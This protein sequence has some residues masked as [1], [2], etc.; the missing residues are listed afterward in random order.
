MRRTL[1]LGAAIAALVTAAH[2]AAAQVEVSRPD[3]AS[4][5]PDSSLADSTPPAA[6]SV[7]Q[8]PEPEL[9]VPRPVLPVAAP[10]RSTP[11]RA[12]V[13]QDLAVDAPAILGLAVSASGTSRD[14]LGLLIS[15]VTPGGPADRGGIDPGTRLAE[16][17]SVNLRIAAADIGRRE[18]EEGALRQ[19][20]RELKTVRPGDYVRLR[21]YGG[22]RYRTMAIQTARTDTTAAN[23][24]PSSSK[25][26]PIVDGIGG[27]RAQLDQLMQEEMVPVSRDT[28][29]VA[30]RELGGIERRLRAA[31]A[32]PR[33]TDTFVGSLPGIRFAAVTNEL[34]DYFGEGSDGG[35]LVLECDLTWDPLRNGDVILRV[36]D[37][38]VTLERLRG[39]L[40]PQRPARLDFMRRGRYLMVT[41]HSRD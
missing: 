26:Q 39:A 33:R 36:N 23:N 29:L 30:E 37:E 1:M 18:S 27:V 15:P 3:S 5:A 38:P 41:L 17:N 4:A 22:G 24:Q 6:D 11:A 10:A 12:P 35:F 13:T 9:P 2:P 40:D 31:L 34:K 16:V 28:L 20:A 7:P 32:A 14:T 25:L 8:I 19:L 21:L